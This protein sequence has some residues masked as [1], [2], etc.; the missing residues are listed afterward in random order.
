MNQWNEI[1]GPWRQ[2]MWDI[3]YFA[4]VT[5]KKKEKIYLIRRLFFFKRISLIPLR[6]RPPWSWAKWRAN[7]CWSEFL[8]CWRDTWWN[9]KEWL[10]P[11]TNSWRR[12]ASSSDRRR[13]D[14]WSVRWRWSWRTNRKWCRIWPTPSSWSPRSCRVPVRR[15]DCRGRRRPSTLDRDIFRTVLEADCSLCWPNL[16]WS[17]RSVSPLLYPCI[18]RDRRH[19]RRC[20]SLGSRKS[21]PRL[22]S[23]VKRGR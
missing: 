23:P 21:I 18:C 5:I 16:S 12:A 8:S 2:K 22:P 6:C 3:F 20:H 15:T 9:S 19:C 10:L 14:G 17:P 7:V 4:A 1:S 13:A 11:S